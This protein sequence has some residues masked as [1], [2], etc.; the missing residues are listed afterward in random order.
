MRSG[1]EIFTQVTG[2]QY[3]YR[4]YG[5]WVAKFWAEWSRLNGKTTKKSPG[6]HLEFRKW[7]NEKFPAPPLPSRRITM[8]PRRPKCG[9]KYKYDKRGAITVRNQKLKEGVALRVYEC[10]RCGMWHVTSK[11]YMEHG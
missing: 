9:T 11:A 6:D 3:H 1:Q 10:N 5:E 7:L 4:L 8:K 2:A